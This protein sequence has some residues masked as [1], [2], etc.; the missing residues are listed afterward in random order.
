MAAKISYNE[1]R[2][3]IVIQ[4]V[5]CDNI[6]AILNHRVDGYGIRSEFDESSGVSGLLISRVK[7]IVYDEGTYKVDPGS[8]AKNTVR[9]II[10]AHTPVH[11]SD[12]KPPVPLYQ[13]GSFVPELTG[14]IDVRFC[15]VIVD[16][17][18]E[19]EHSTYVIK[20]QSVVTTLTSDLYSST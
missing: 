18:K 14:T 11:L 17:I 19:M 15:G 3:D 16:K 9:G 12:G 13:L 10:A 4:N 1:V 8:I 6:K 2:G 7:S 20:Y 5:N